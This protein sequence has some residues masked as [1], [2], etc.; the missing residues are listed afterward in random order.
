MI[1]YSKLL[2]LTEGIQPYLSLEDKTKR[3]QGKILGKAKGV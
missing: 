3:E 1:T 2:G